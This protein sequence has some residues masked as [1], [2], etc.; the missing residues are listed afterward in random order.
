VLDFRPPKDSPVLLSFVKLGLP[1]YMKF[2]LHDTQVQPVPG[3]VERFGAVKGK[4]GMICPNHS[5]RHD[6]QVMFE[7]SRIVKEDF[8]YIAAREV[9]DWDNGRN[10]WWIQHLGAYSVVRGA[11]DRESFKMSRKIIAE[12]KKKLVLFPEGE[13]SRQND[14]LMALESGAPQLCFWAVEELSKNSSDSNAPIPPVLLI[15]VALKYTFTKDVTPELKKTVSHLEEE[16]GLMSSNDNPLMERLYALGQTLLSTLER[17]YGCQSTN[18]Q[19]TNKRIARL[20]LHILKNAADQ[21]HIKLP[22]SGKELDSVR[23]I[24]NTLD[25]F[26]YSDE[27]P[28]SDYERK[29]HDEKAKVIRGLYKDMERVVNF[30]AIYD[31]YLA[32]HNTQEQFSDVLDRV[33]TE[34]LRCREPSFRGPRRVLVDVGT[35]IDMTARYADYKKDKRNVLSKTIEEVSGQLTSMLTRL[36]QSRSPFIVQ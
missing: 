6:P 8:N 19:E 1:L 24:R 33:E 9:F 7:F 10:G 36:E 21:L 5:N 12:G 29:L 14:T 23:I 2:Q 30:I 16:V 34:V 13:I 20:R 26:I 4:R 35:P 17:E 11:A 18:G 31:G 25:D 22:D 27:T 32:E 15:P 3:A 28:K